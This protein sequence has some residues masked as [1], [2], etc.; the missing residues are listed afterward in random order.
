MGI[1]ASRLT[2]TS[3]FKKTPKVRGIMRFDNSGH[4]GIVKSIKKQMDYMGQ[5]VIYTVAYAHSSCS[6]SPCLSR[7]TFTPTFP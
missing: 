4:I 6:N 2:S 3:Y 1:L 5:T 7:G